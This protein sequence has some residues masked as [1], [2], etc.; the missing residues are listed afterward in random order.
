MYK[1]PHLNIKSAECSK[2]WYEWFELFRN[3]ETRNSEETKK[4][5]QK[6]CK[7][8]DE[9]GAM[10]HQAYLDMPHKPRM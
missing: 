2:L 4:A 1:E 10:I 6:W 7:C 9:H 3:I 5:R 8:S